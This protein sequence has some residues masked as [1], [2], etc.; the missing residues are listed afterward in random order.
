M[1]YSKTANRFP[2]AEAAQFF[3]QKTAFSYQFQRNKAALSPKKGNENKATALQ[4][5]LVEEYSKQI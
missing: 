1:Y 2:I 4:E 3:S 5:V